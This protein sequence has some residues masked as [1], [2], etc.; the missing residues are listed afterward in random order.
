ML[1][2]L[3]PDH[4]LSVIRMLICENSKRTIRTLESINE[5]KVD[6]EMLHKLYA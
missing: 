2:I 1:V 5:R 3:A 6:G 4:G